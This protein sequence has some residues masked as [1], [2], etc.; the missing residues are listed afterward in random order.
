MLLTSSDAR[1]FSSVVFPALS[2]PSRTMR[3][4][5]SGEP[6]SFWMTESSPCGHG[7][8]GEPCGA[9]GCCRAPLFWRGKLWAVGTLCLWPACTPGLGFQGVQAQGGPVADLPNRGPPPGALSLPWE[10]HQLLGVL[11]GPSPGYSP[12]PTLPGCLAPQPGAGAGTPTPARSECHQAP[13]T[14]CTSPMA[15]ESL[16]PAARLRSCRGLVPG[17][18][19]RLR[20]WHAPHPRGRKRITGSRI[21][22]RFSI[23]PQH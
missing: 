20:D 3:S 8:L 16:R 15:W 22:G 23:Y 1:R 18:C 19:R 5:C 21:S 13:L 9:P 12:G 17:A 7:G 14:F 2:S 4:S 6:L 11:G 10:P